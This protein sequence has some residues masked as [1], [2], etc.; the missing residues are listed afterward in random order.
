MPLK[1][2]VCRCDCGCGRVTRDEYPVCPLCLDGKHPAN[3]LLP[4]KGV[5]LI[6]CGDCDGFMYFDKKVKMFKCG[7]FCE[8]RHSCD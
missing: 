4:P 2:I 5:D 3:P 8:R 7:P 1:V 6:R